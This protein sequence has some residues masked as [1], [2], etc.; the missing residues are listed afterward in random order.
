M[1]LQTVRVNRLVFYISYFIE[2]SGLPRILY[3]G[4]L[5]IKLSLAGAALQ[6]DYMG[7]MPSLI[8][9]T[10]LQSYALTAK[11]LKY[12]Y[13]EHHYFCRPPSGV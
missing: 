9:Q 12:F 6:A 2:A 13:C 11:T 5:T 1:H 7:P 8:C 4:L 10:A 3:L